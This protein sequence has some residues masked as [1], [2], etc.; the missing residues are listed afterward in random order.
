MYPPEL[1]DAPETHL[2]R[3][4]GPAGGTALLPKVHIHAPSIH[5]NRGVHFYHQKTD[6]LKLATLKSVT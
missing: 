2:E 5:N 3:A 1:P 4:L 6:T